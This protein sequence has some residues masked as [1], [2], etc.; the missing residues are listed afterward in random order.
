MII[1][2]IELLKYLIIIK[3]ILMERNNTYQKKILIIE[4]HN[5]TE[6][7]I[8][9]EFCKKNMGKSVDLVLEEVN[10]I[11]SIATNNNMKVRGYISTIADCPYE[12]NID[13]EKVSILVE[14]LINLGC[15]EV[16]LG[17]KYLPYPELHII[18]C[19]FEINSKAK[20]PAW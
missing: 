17:D 10:K 19:L 16:S 1:K 20:H 8:I 4:H 9:D 3:I 14:K 7:G 15:Y 12:G 5:E 2:K 18:F 13:P 11:M 6:I